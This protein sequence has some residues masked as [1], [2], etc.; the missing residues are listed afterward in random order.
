MVRAFEKLVCGRS[1]AAEIANMGG[2]IAGDKRRLGREGA[3]LETA[4]VGG[5]VFEKLVYGSMERAA[6]IAKTI[7]LAKKVLGCKIGA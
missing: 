2:S 6:E 4:W 1:R 5:L 7:P 3:E